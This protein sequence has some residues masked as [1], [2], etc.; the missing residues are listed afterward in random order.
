M[1]FGPK[2]TAD[3][4]QPPAHKP[5]GALSRRWQKTV[6]AGAAFLAVGPAVTPTTPPAPPASPA[7]AHARL[8]LPDH[9]GAITSTSCIPAS[10]VLGQKAYPQIR[11]VFER[12]TRQPISGAPVITRVTTP[13]EDV[14]ACTSRD[15]PDGNMVAAYESQTRRLIVARRDVAP[16]TVAHEVFHAHQHL[17]GGFT[18][19][20]SNRLLT[21]GDRATALLLI[22][23]TAAAYAMVVIKEA[24]LND[25]SYARNIRTHDYGMTRTFNTAFDASYAANADKPEAERRREA[26]QAGGQAVVRALM[27]GQSS[28]WKSMYRSEA[29]RYLG[30]SSYSGERGSEYRAERD[31]LYAKIG[32]VSAGLQLVPPEFMGASANDSISASQKAIG[33]RVPADAPAAQPFA[34]TPRRTAA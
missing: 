4:T 11:P 5:K 3:T 25:P 21:A 24:G 13:T 23:S 26:L 6:L 30:L 7:D 22:E 10:E 12:M 29:A 28:E 34:S 20:G 1:R 14:D 31:R 9:L 18:S 17:S 16:S 8:A 2:K 15:L 27:N 33:L 32:N 19:A